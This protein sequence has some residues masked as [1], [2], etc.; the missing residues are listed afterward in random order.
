MVERHFH[1]VRMFGDTIAAMCCA[2]RSDRG[3]CTAIF[4]W[5]HSSNAIP[6][7]A[8]LNVSESNACVWMGGGGGGYLDVA[9]STGTRY[10]NIGAVDVCVLFFV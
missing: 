3:A 9:K 8:H 4:S 5:S 2:V 10:H 6:R 7:I 1:V